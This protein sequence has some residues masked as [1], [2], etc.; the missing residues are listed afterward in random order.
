MQTYR[1]LTLAHVIGVTTP[2]YQLNE[3]T[4]NYDCGAISR[5]IMDFLTLDG[6]KVTKIRRNSDNV[7]FQIG[8][9]L[10]VGGVQ[11]A[12]NTIVFSA[13][14][15]IFTLVNSVSTVS[16]DT[17]IKY[18][19]PVAQPAQVAQR[20]S[21]ARTT[22]NTHT[23]LTSLQTQLMNSFDGGSG[24][25]VRLPGVLKNRRTQTAAQFLEK[26]FRDWNNS[27][28]EESR[29]KNT[30]Y[31]DDSTIQ[32]ES[33]RR[34]S[35]GDLFMIVKYYYPNITLA[36]VVRILYVE[37][38]N[39]ITDGF[40]SSICSQIRKRVWYYEPHQNSQN[41]V[42]NSTSNDEYGHPVQWYR[43]RV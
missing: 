23:D 8:E 35:L 18:V 15:A 34:R 3:R 29:R 2:T 5:N 7:V 22:T 27:R 6:V 25:T 21:A 31:A 10:T 28:T 11:R 36:E 9:T 16:L 33:G 26:F 37:L 1:I 17:A 12:I 20:P 43:D 32:T 38:P 39:R 13:G 30:I 19:A 40:R 4:G 42:A 41:N 14:I 24:R